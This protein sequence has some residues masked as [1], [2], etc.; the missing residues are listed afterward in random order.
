MR[1]MV[2][3]YVDDECFDIHDYDDDTDDDTNDDTDDDTDDG[4][5]GNQ[6]I[7]V[8]AG[9]YE[10]RFQGNSRT[11]RRVREFRWKFTFRAWRQASRYRDTEYHLLLYHAERPRRGR[12]IRLRTCTDAWHVP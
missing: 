3:M 1:P 2:L 6:E 11:G 4:G 7:P 8:P 10:G 9:G 12:R 5:R